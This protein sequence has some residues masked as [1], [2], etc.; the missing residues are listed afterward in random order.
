MRFLPKFI[1]NNGVVFFN[2]GDGVL[3]HRLEEKWENMDE[4]PMIFMDWP[5]I[6]VRE[7]E[8]VLKSRTTQV[9]ITGKDL[10]SLKSPKRSLNAGL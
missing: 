6:E 3:E 1:N 10:M 7:D 9:T 8:I 4:S 2:I 5:N